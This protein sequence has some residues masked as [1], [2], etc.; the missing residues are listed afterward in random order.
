MPHQVFARTTNGSGGNWVQLNANISGTVNCAFWSESANGTFDMV[1]NAV[2]LTAAAAER[3]ADRY[4]VV[5][6]SSGAQHAIRYEL[7]PCKTW[8]RSHTATGGFTWCHAQW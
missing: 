3:T 1:C 8:I 2:D 7:D 6:V 4:T 5:P